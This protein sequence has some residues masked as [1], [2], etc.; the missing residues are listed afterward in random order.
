MLGVAM[1]CVLV[2][3]A[4]AGGY[5]NGKHSSANRDPATLSHN[6]VPVD[7][8]AR[9]ELEK[10]FNWCGEELDLC[11]ASW[12]QHIGQGY[13]GSC[14][15]HGTLSAIQDRLKI[16]K[17]GRGIDVML[18]RQVLL[19]CGAF[20]NFGAG[21]DGGDVIDTFHYM[22]KYGLPDESCQLYSAT[23]HTKYP[24][25]KKCPAIGKCMNCMPVKDVSTCWPVRTP[26]LYK[27]KSFGQLKD[28]SELGMMSEIRKN[29][30]IT[31]SIATP[32]DFIYKYRSGIVMDGEY[33]KSDVDHDIE[34]VGWGEEDGTKFWIIRNSW[35]TFW[36]ELGFFRV[37]RGAPKNGTLQIE[38]GDCWASEP[39]F[40]MEEEVREG[41]LVGSMYGV[42]D[43]DSAADIETQPAVELQPAT[44]ATAAADSQTRGSV[45]LSRKAGAFAVVA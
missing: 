22:T 19:N 42:L 11:T 45:S 25:A 14:W 32:E 40:E 29:G 39:E 6:Y 31:C 9:H 5:R 30:P 1:L 28:G 44:V 37:E 41:E 23:D 2:P 20:D 38:S 35:G 16:R 4:F 36:G 15:V 10:S 27:L 3:Q 33:D 8:L 34:V 26:I 21:C 18:A 13:C 7:T 17:N 24:G 43:A 12:N